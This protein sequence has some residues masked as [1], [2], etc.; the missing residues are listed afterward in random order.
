MSTLTYFIITIKNLTFCILEKKRKKW[1]K[2]VRGKKKGEKRKE[3]GK[4]SEKK[5][6]K[7]KKGEK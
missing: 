1:G 2:R 5:R 7:K 3:I 4:E 6:R